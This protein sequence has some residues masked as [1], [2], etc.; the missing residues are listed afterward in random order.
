MGRH[1]KTRQGKER[2]RCLDTAGG[3]GPLLHSP[4]IPLFLRKR[5]CILR[6][7]QSFPTLVWN[8]PAMKRPKPVERRAPP[9]SAA[10]QWR[11]KARQVLQ[12]G[13]RNWDG[14]CKKVQ[15]GQGMRA[16][17]RGRVGRKSLVG[18]QANGLG[19]GRV[20]RLPLRLPIQT[21][22]KKIPVPSSSTSH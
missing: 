10:R 6:Q 1:L 3:E 2:C 18:I 13:Q 20:Q 16:V 14:F 7:T 21:E 15:L 9:S 5:E 8:P 19:V 17:L 12:W 4:W 22:S 11:S